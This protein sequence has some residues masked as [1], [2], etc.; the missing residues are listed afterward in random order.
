V[1][2]N[3]RGGLAALI[4]IDRGGGVDFGGEGDGMGLVLVLGARAGLRVRICRHG[5]K[6][7]YCLQDV[8]G[9]R[10]RASE[11]LTYHGL[12]L[13]QSRRLD[14]QL[15][16]EVLAHLPL[17]FVD[18]SRLEPCPTMLQDLFE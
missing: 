8:R 12:E 5:S 6:L 10:S 3:G 2:K 7:G 16:I 15:P 14:V 13:F 4:G 1:T 18:L 17:H 11:I 9:V